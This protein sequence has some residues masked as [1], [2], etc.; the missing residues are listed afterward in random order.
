M[1]IC[2]NPP[3]FYFGSLFVI[4]YILVG[5]VLFEPFST[6]FSANDIL[7]SAIV[8]QPHLFSHPVYSTIP[9]IQKPTAL[10]S[11]L[12]LPFMNV[13]LSRSDLAPPSPLSAPVCLHRLFLLHLQL[14]RQRSLQ[15]YL[16]QSIGFLRSFLGVFG[17][18][19][20][21][22]ISNLF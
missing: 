10:I 22:L 13:S 2:Q 14:I 9:E 21:H 3:I 17:F 16:L 19:L 5:D 11:I 1:Y 12:P 6:V 4:N 8:L 7:I 20:N 18:I 15:V